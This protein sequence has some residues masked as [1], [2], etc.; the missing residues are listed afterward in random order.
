MLAEGF[1]RNSGYRV[2]RVVLLTF[3]CQ[4]PSKRGF[5]KS[6]NTKVCL[7]LTLRRRHYDAFL[8]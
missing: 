6:K 5:E 3:G 4:P 2:E 7:H 8:L 1:L